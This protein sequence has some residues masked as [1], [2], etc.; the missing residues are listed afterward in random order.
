MSTK[1]F[2]DRKCGRGTA[3]LYEYASALQYKAFVAS[4]Y[5][6]GQRVA[7]IYRDEAN[8]YY[9]MQ[10]GIVEKQVGHAGLLPNTPGWIA[11]AR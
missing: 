3:D 6:G 9:A 8:Q 2:I 5:G 7:Q 4:A 11:K 10:Y 1:A